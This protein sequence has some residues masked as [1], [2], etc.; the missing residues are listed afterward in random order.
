[1]TNDPKDD[2]EGGQYYDTSPDSS[3]RRANEPRSKSIN[4]VE[5]GVKLGDRLPKQWQS[6]DGIKSAR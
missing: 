4:H 3:V 6:L 5:E 2:V 1:M